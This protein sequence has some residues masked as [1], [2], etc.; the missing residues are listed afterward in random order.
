MGRSV[1]QSVC[2]SVLKKFRPGHC[3][4]KNLDLDICLQNFF[5]QHTNGYNDSTLL[6]SLTQIGHITNPPWLIPLLFM[7]KQFSTPAKLQP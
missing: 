2:L 6:Y 5:D 7:R 1:G 3:P 4:Q